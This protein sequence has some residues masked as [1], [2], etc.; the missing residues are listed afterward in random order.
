MDLK[1]V[2]YPHTLKDWQGLHQNVNTGFKQTKKRERRNG[3]RKIH[4]LQ[5]NL[6]SVLK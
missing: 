2:K 3:A 4:L 6:E 1:E 5:F